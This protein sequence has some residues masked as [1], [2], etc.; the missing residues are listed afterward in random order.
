MKVIKIILIVLLIITLLIIV[1]YL[2]LDFM[3]NNATTSKETLINKITDYG[4]T[5]SSTA[6]ELYKNTFDELADTLSSK[7]VDNDKYA[8]LVSELF[9]IDFYTLD[10][11]PTKNDVGGVQFIYKDEKDNFI[12]KASD[13][14]YKYVESNLNGNRTQKLPIVKSVEVTNTENISYKYG[15]K[16]D[17]NAYK[18]TLS[19]KYEED[20]GYQD[21]ATLT[22]IHDGNKLAIVEEA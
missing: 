9:I 4:Y 15:T 18:V 21:S 5:C 6:T 19:W 13:T 17:S 1:G 10:N 12:T 3:P 20:L 14:I 16:T 22:L 7:S 11:K 2:L 8:E